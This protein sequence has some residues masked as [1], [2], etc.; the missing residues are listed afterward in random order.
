[1]REKFVG[2]Y[3]PLDSEFTELWKNGLFILD[4]NVLLNLYRYPKQASDDLLKVLEQLSNRLWIPHQAALEYQENRLAVIS[5]Q[6]KRFDDVRKVLKNAENNLSEE[7]SRLQLR[8]RH[9]TID[10]DDFLEKVKGEFSKFEASLNQLEKDQPDIFSE[11]VLRNKID[12]LLGAKVG[13]PFPFSELEKVYQEGKTRYEHKCPPGYEDVTKGKSGEKERQFYFCNGLTI[14]RE[15]GDL[16]LWF[17]IIN[18]VKTRGIKYVVFVTDDE[19]EDWWWIAESKGKKTIGPRPE[20]IDEIKH[21]AD[22]SLFHMYN[23][24]RFLQCAKKYLDVKIE[25]ES[26]KQVQEI[27]QLRRAELENQSI[28]VTYYQLEQA[29]V[30][31]IKISYPNDE[32]IF[33]KGIGVMPGLIRIGQDGSRVGYEIKYISKSSPVKDISLHQADNLFSGGRLNKL[34]FVMTFDNEILANKMNTFLRSYRD[35]PPKNVSV[36]FGIVVTDDKAEGSLYKF[37]PLPEV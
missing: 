26:V 15:Y 25:P 29:V 10:P 28:Q 24:E 18:E 22:I 11:D 12:R 14:S 32:I 20:L 30:E 31:W 6:V 19:K 16:I 7:L 4:A 5:E 8:K 35:K 1:M 17:Q 21:K 36:V 3:K 27:T 33:S 9:S 34:V 37:I 13:N 23:S 2:Y